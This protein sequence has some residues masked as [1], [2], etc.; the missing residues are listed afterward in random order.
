MTL[1][2]EPNRAVRLPSWPPPALIMCG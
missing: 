2:H 1:A